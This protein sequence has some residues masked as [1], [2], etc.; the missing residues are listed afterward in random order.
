MQATAIADGCSTP[1][2]HKRNPVDSVPSSSSQPKRHAI[3]AV[4]MRAITSSNS[5]DLKSNPAA[6][7][8]RYQMSAEAA[9]LFETLQESPLPLPSADTNEEVCR[10]F[11]HSIAIN[12]INNQIFLM[13]IVNG[14]WNVCIAAD[15]CI[16]VSKSDTR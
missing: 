8:V 4:P 9:K 14:D 13:F 1:I 12:N 5:F 3:S 16:T 2:S 11:T 15:C 10:Y 6:L 7:P